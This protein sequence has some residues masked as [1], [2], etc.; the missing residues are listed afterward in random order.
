M[1]NPFPG[2]NPYIEAQGRWTGFH[3]LLIA[4]C[5]E[6]LTELL[7]ENYATFVEERLEVI[8]TPSA[9]PRQRQPDLGIGL[10]IG[11]KP[12]VHAGASAVLDFE[13]TMLTLPDHLENPEAYIDIRSLPD[14]ELVTSI[15][16]LSPSN[17]DPSVHGEY[18]PKRYSMIRQGINLVE[19]DLLL[20]GERLDAL[21]PLPV[22]D[23]FAFISRREKRPQCEVFHWSIRRPI[24]RL[25]VPLRAPDPD[26]VLDLNAAFNAVYDRHGYDRTVR[27]SNPLPR[28]LVTQ[29]NPTARKK[30]LF[31]CAIAM[32]LD[33]TWP[34]E[35]RIRIRGL[36]SSI[37]RR[38]RTCNT[39]IWVA[40]V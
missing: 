3:N 9:R 36:E 11:S 22:G 32:P 24:P 16:I 6:M 25:P 10:E 2:V 19:I 7:P 28:S 37:F 1:A 38:S 33:Y 20:G 29:S 27:Y 30:I 4:Q 26:V 18:W 8:D 21:E 34:K 13:P 12:S 40:A 17:K 31:K 35:P 14:Q 23:F 39:S 15:E 5:S